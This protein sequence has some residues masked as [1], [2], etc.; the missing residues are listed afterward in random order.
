MQTEGQKRTQFTFY[1][2]FLT[3]VEQLPKSRKYEALSAIIRYGLY[4]ETPSEMSR[5]AAGVFAIARPVL[6]AGRSR[7]SRVRGCAK[8][9]ERRPA[10]DPLQLQ[11]QDKVK[12]KA[13]D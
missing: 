10:S 4:G 1:E 9:E 11:E 13:E 6:D 2:S 12:D 8:A 7:A 3:A 5:A